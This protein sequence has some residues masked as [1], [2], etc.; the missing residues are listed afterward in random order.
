MMRQWLL[1]E[2]QGNSQQMGKLEAHFPGSQAP[3]AREGQLSTSTDPVVHNPPQLFSPEGD[4]AW[5]KCR[6]SLEKPFSLREG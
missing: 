3:M 5:G 2:M 4:L 1:R 6:D